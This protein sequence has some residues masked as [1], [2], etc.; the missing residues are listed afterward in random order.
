M[1]WR[2]APSPRWASREYWTSSSAVNRR[3]SPISLRYRRVASKSPSPDRNRSAA[4]SIPSTLPESVLSESSPTTS[5]MSSE[6]S[7]SNIRDSLSASR[8]PLRSTSTSM[9]V[10]SRSSAVDIPFFLRPA[11]LRSVT[12]PTRQRAPSKG[13]HRRPR[14]PET[15]R[16]S[17]GPVSLGSD[18]STHRLLKASDPVGRIRFATRRSQR[19]RLRVRGDGAGRGSDRQPHHRDESRSAAD[20]PPPPLDHIRPGP[21]LA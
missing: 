21:V 15:S 5:V 16:T 14:A 2:A 1:R 3:A 19:C 17:R 7:D 11:G 10:V 13:P 6:S 18:Q 9:V 12:P 8:S 4:V 20:G